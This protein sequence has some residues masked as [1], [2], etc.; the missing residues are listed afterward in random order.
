MK[1]NGACYAWLTGMP[2]L[3]PM[4]KPYPVIVLYFP[5]ILSPSTMAAR[6]KGNFTLPQR[7]GHRSACV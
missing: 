2:V 4:I 5:A 3:S 6:S 7:D 1:A